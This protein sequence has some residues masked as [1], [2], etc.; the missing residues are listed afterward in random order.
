MQVK[1]EVNEGLVALETISDFMEGVRTVAIAGHENPDGDCV[2]A[3]IACY[4][5]LR[6]TCP[7]AQVDVYLEEVR[8]EFR[9]LEG[10]EQVRTVCD[11]AAS[12]DLMILMDISSVERIGV[13]GP[14]FANAKKTICFDHHVTNNGDFS[15]FF[16]YPGSSSTCEVF[17]NYLDAQKVT[18][19]IAEALFLGIVHDTGVFRFRSVTPKTHMLAA[20]L[21]GRGIDATRI[22]EETFF[23]RSYEQQR[24]LGRVLQEAQ[25]MLDG[26]VIVSTVSRADM[27]LYGLQPRDMDGVV[28][29]LNNVR[30]VPVAVF[31]YEVEEGRQKVSLRSKT[32]DVSKVAASFG[33]GGHVRAAGATIDGPAMEVIAKLLPLL[34]KTLAEPVAEEPGPLVDRQM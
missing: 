7:D 20:N 2:G 29:Q 13:A 24:L 27:E 10:T 31:I 11:P 15:W 34:E 32:V 14:L 12:Y 5:Y 8:E 19:P 25:L 9:F 4:L 28:S 22:I 6:S 16:N 30:G 21:M 3:C 33:G 23:Y 26:R 1:Q 17:S 18:K